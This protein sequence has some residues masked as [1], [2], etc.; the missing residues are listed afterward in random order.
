MEIAV[1]VI[2][3]GIVFYFVSK[4][5]TNFI[6]NDFYLEKP[7]MSKA[8][9]CKV[10]DVVTLRRE[11]DKKIAVYDQDEKIGLIPEDY[12]HIVERQMKEEPDVHP[13]IIAINKGGFK[14][15]MELKGEVR[16]I[17]R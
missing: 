2:V 16:D 5:F 13:K 7:D 9:V 1:V 14:I 4:R 17:I 15:A 10:G 6:R 11:G 3:I 8:T 12:L